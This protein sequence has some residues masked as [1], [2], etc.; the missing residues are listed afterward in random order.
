MKFE[1]TVKDV[2]SLLLFKVCICFLEDDW[3]IFDW[4]DVSKLIIFMFPEIVLK[5]SLFLC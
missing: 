3:C 4:V 5:V 2:L 1:N